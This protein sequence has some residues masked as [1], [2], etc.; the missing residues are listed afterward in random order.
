MGDGLLCPA[1]TNLNTVKSSLW[2]SPILTHGLSRA[3]AA[4]AQTAVG[5][6]G[7]RLAKSKG[8]FPKKGFKEIK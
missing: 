7:K 1:L 2:S 3:P 5:K 8:F 4:W 6:I